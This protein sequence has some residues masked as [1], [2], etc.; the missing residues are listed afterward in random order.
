MKTLILI[1]S[2][3]FLSACNVDAFEINA[4]EYY[5]RDKGGVRYI[6]TKLVTTMHCN[7]NN[8]AMITNGNIQGIENYKKESK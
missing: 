8:A 2:F 7:N 4:A 5:C 3:L 1:S 6:D